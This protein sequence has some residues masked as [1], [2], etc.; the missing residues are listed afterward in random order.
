MLLLTILAS[1]GMFAVKYLESLRGN[2]GAVTGSVLRDTLGEVCFPLG[3]GVLYVL[4]GGNKLLYSIPI[5][6]LT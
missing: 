2:L 3:A 5:L 6:I 4:S 1:A